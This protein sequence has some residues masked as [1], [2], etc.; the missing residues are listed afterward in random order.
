MLKA[1]A[2]STIC[3][4]VYVPQAAHQACWFMTAIIQYPS[5]IGR[6]QYQKRFPYLSTKLEA[7]RKNHRVDTS[8]PTVIHCKSSKHDMEPGW[9]DTLGCELH[10]LVGR[11]TKQWQLRSWGD[12]SFLRLF[13]LVP[14]GWRPSI[15]GSKRFIGWTL[16]PSHLFV[17]AS[18]LEG[19]AAWKTDSNPHV[20]RDTSR[21]SDCD[22]AS[23]ARPTMSKVCSDVGL[24]SAR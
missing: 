2:V 19:I 7:D 11:C 5:L 17:R 23:N 21:Q 9:S 20:V 22:P 15:V 1:V 10:S 14:C 18:C 3:C 24:K 16:V 6:Q 12:L 13:C 4:G 8:E